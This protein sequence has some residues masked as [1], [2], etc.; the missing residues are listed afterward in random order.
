MNVTLT[1]VAG[2][3]AG[4]EFAFDRHDTFLVGRAKDAHFQ[5]SADD[6]YFSRRHFL[7][8]VNPPRVRVYDLNSRN[9]IAVNGQKVRTADLADGDELKAGHTVFRVGVPQPPELDVRQTLDLP[10]SRPGP[11]ATVQHR[12]GPEIPGYAIEQ[13]LGRGAMGVV[14]RAAREADGVAV[15]VKVITPAAGVSEKDAQRFLREARIM[16]MLEHRNIVRCLD[17]GESEGRLY[18]VMELVTGPDLAARVKERGPMDVPTAVRLALHMLEGLAHAHAKGFVHRDVKPSNL[19]LDGPKKQRLVKV[20]DFGLARAYND[21]NISGLTMQGDV[22]GT[23][24]FM[25]PEQVTHY[26]DVKPAADQYAAAATLY[27]LLTGRYVLNFEQGAQAQMIQ[28]ATDPRVPIRSR[29]PDLPPALADAIHKA[30]SL[31]PEKR[32]PDVTALR[33]VLRSFA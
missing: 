32:F 27:Y 25:A 19:L 15:A 17:S 8:E 4:R 29:R 12:V 2:P 13:E 31:D 20:A 21:C 22:G 16:T 3:H 26:R 23:P 14:Y 24:A 5:L 7:L 18:L 6:P 10:A 28:I 9:G 33:E 11:E 1:V 30:L